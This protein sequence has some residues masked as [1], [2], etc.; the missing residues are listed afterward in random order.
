MEGL[1][2]PARPEVYPKCEH[3]FPVECPENEMDFCWVCGED[4]PKAN[5]PAINLPLSQ[6]AVPHS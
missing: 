6:I 2:I 5:A 1:L 4:I 3:R